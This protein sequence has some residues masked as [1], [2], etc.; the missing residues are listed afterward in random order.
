VRSATTPCAYPLAVLSVCA[1]L[2]T[3]EGH[4]V[5]CPCYVNPLSATWHSSAQRETAK[6]RC[7]LS[8]AKAFNGQVRLRCRHVIVGLI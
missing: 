5:C 4:R 2:F 1:S 8:S 3:V 6:E 7:G